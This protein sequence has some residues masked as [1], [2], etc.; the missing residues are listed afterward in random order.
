MS[1]KLCQGPGCRERSLRAIPSN[2][3]L[4]PPLALPLHH[5]TPYHQDDP[6]LVSVMVNVEEKN[7]YKLHAATYVQGEETSCELGVGLHNVSGNAEHLTVSG[8]IGTQRSTQLTAS[9]EQPKPYD[10]PVTV[11]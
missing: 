9:Y 8:E 3:Q 5:P 4:F 6:E 11:R 10:L 1:H 2:E 7:W